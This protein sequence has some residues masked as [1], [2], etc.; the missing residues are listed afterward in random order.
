MSPLKRHRSDEKELNEM[1]LLK[2]RRS[3]EEEQTTTEKAAVAKAKAKAGVKAKA[4]SNKAADVEEETTVKLD[5][6]KA[7]TLD[8]ADLEA[9]TIVEL[10]KIAKS[11]KLEG[12]STLNKTDLIALVGSKKQFDFRA[13]KGNG[14][15]KQ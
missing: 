4:A 15:K 14:S 13:T 7:D 9:K 8:I 2:R 1:S 11:P 6:A 5:A 10:R 3:D 12:F